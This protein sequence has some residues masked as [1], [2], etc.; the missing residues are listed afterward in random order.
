MLAD[1][2]RRRILELLTKGERSVGE[3]H[4][5]F[6]ISGPAVSQHLKV[7]KEAGLVSARVDA[8]RRIYSLNPEP[9]NQMVKW[10]TGVG[11]FW[12]EKLDALERELGKGD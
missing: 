12:N 10:L 8:Q 11:A 2:S 7:L 5:E 1:P 3:I 6:A 9:L 4:K